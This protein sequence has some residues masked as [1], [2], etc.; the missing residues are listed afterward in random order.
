MGICILVKCHLYIETTTK[1]QSW[2]YL[3]IPLSISG[4]LFGDHCWNFYVGT[5]SYLSSHCSSL[6]K[7][8]KNSYLTFIWV[9]VSWQSN[10]L[11]ILCFQS[12]LPGWH[13][14]DRKLFCFTFAKFILEDNVLV[15]QTAVY[16]LQ[17]RQSYIELIHHRSP[18]HCLLWVFW[19]VCFDSV[20]NWKTICLTHIMFLFFQVGV[21]YYIIYWY[22]VQVMVS[23]LDL[24]FGMLLTF[25]YGCHFADDIFKV[26]FL[27]EIVIFWLKFHWNVLPRVQSKYGSIGS[28]N[29]LAAMR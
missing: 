27:N 26:I 25:A 29:G 20:V 7:P 19:R 2:F 9:V 4:M 6:K 23:T 18:L 1:P 17:A 3:Q 12:L 5:L 11:L 10:R 14:L 21:L 15:T 16:V 13:E 8:T 24:C 28:D 22:Y